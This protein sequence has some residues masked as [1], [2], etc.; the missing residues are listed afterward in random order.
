MWRNEHME[1]EIR[2]MQDPR[3]GE[4][5]SGEYLEFGYI[6]VT[7]MDGQ[8]IFHTRMRHERPQADPKE[9]WEVMEKR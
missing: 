8:N 6:R 4:I 5:L 3:K 7:Y 1:S 9:L 2:E